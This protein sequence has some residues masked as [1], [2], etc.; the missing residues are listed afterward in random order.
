MATRTRTRKHKNTRMQRK[1]K[2]DIIPGSGNFFRMNAQKG[3]QRLLY[4][5]A[6]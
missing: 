6:A 4:R 3:V 2:R 1:E 5:T